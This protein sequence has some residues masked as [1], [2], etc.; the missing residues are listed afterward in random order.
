MA[1]GEVVVLAI[2]ASKTPSQLSSRFNQ[3]PPIFLH[4]TPF[5]C[6]RGAKSSYWTNQQFI[7]RQFI[8][9]L[10]YYA[11]DCVACAMQYM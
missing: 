9:Q 8:V 4:P 3:E 7:K 2:F 1:V 11:E 5:N 10:S 6:S